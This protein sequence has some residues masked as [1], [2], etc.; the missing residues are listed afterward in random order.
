MKR[1]IAMVCRPRLANT[2]AMSHPDILDRRRQDL[3]LGALEA[4]PGAPR[5]AGGASSV[6]GSSSAMVLITVSSSLDAI[7]VACPFAVDRPSHHRARVRLEIGQ[8]ADPVSHFPCLNLSFSQTWWS[9]W[10]QRPARLGQ[11]AGRVAE[12]LL[13]ARF[14]FLDLGFGAIRRVPGDAQVHAGKEAGRAYA[15]F[16]GDNSRLAHLESLA[17][18]CGLPAAFHPAM[19]MISR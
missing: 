14:A 10:P 6:T 9:A 2:G 17:S 7:A 8:N 3:Y 4:D 18:H 16:S 5:R 13:V 15:N 1:S 12:Q 19:L 11:S